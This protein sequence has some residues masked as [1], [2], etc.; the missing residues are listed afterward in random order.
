MLAIFLDIVFVE[1]GAVRDILEVVV[2]EVEDEE[3]ESRFILKVEL[4][5]DFEELEFVVEIGVALHVAAL[6]LYF[7]TSSFALPSYSA[8]HSTS[9]C[10]HGLQCT[11][12]HVPTSQPST[13]QYIVLHL[14]QTVTAEAS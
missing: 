5:F 2:G 14:K 3:T 1:V 12:F 11:V 9:R 6:P 8:L 7:T 13:L 10:S 4:V